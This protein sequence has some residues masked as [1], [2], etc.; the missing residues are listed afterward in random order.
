MPKT[1][2]IDQIFYGI[3][4]DLSQDIVNDTQASA[5]QLITLSAQFLDSDSQDLLSNYNQLCQHE[6]DEKKALESAQKNMASVIQKDVSIRAEINVVMSAM[7][8]SELLRQ[9]LEGVKCSYNILTHR[10]GLSDDD[11]KELMIN[12][13]HTID[14]R[15]AYYE[16]V[17]FQEMPAEDDEVSQ[18]LIDQ[19]IG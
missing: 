16:K 2:D 3:A 12:E 18:D 9:H 11:V 15:R 5:E 13:M 19:L 7:Q 6:G 1:E 17:M 8:F 14:E 10:Q 4:C